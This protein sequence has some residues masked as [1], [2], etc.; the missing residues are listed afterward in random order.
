MANFGQIDNTAFNHRWLIEKRTAL[1]IN[2]IYSLP[3]RPGIA[4]LLV[5]GTTSILLVDNKLHTLFFCKKIQLA[6]KQKLVNFIMQTC[7]INFNR[8]FFKIIF[9]LT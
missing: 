9:L 4:R 3:T 7:C 8:F 2:I 5:F 1:A 6:G